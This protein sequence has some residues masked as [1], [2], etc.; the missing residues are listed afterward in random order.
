M[1][2]ERQKAFMELLKARGQL[3]GRPVVRD[4][5]WQDDIQGN[6]VTG[7]VKI[8]GGKSDGDDDRGI[9]A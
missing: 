1:T 8:N 4:Y 5:S 7:S 9:H 2:P 6:I 3:R